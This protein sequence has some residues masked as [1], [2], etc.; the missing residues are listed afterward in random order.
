L[1]HISVPSLIGI[2]TC[3]QSLIYSTCSCQ[4]SYNRIIYFE[5]SFNLLPRLITTS[6]SIFFLNLTFPVTM[7]TFVIKYWLG[8]YYEIPNDHRLIIYCFAHEIILY[9][10]HIL[11]SWKNQD[12]R[13]SCKRMKSSPVR[14]NR[15]W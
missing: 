9:F 1:L 12:K 6:Q 15:K 4:Y 3:L 5:Y 13:I 8:G 7:I 11:L 10:K 14:I 2:W